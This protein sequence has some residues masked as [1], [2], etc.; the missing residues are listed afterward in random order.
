MITISLAQKK[1]FDVAADAYVFLLEQDFPFSSLEL[2]KRLYAPLESLLKERKFTGKAESSLL[3]TGVHE[4]KGVYLLLIGLGARDKHKKLS[5]EFYRRGI[6]RMVRFAESNQ[7]KKVV[8]SLAD[9]GHFGITVERLAQETSTIVFKSS[10][11]FDDFITSPER[12]L[13]R[14]TD[15]ICTLDR[16]HMKAAEAGL[17][18]GCI[19]AQSLNS[20][21]YWCDLPPCVLTPEKLAEHAESIGKECHLKTTIFDTKDIKKMGMGGLMAVSQGSAQ[22][23]RLA[24]LEYH[25]S[26]KAPTIALVGKGI[27]FDSGG[28][29]IKPAQGMETMKDDMSGAAA[30]LASMKAIAQLKPSVNVIG[31]APMAENMPSGTATRPGDIITFYNGKTA[32]VKNT[33]AEGRLILADA[34]AYAVKHYQL[35]AI[36]DLATLTGACSYALGPFYTGLFTQDD[37]LAGRLEAAAKTSGDRVWRLPMDE[38]YRKAVR[39]EV[40]D[41]C[42]SGNPAYRAGAIT[43]AFFL[44]NFVNS[45]PW[46]HLDIAGTA[47]G[48]PDLTYVRPGATGVGIRLLIDMIENW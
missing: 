39:S 22:G 42:N 46:A 3:V 16:K 27:T 37:D 47:F 17:Q 24:V 30:V 4:G 2:A 31:L 5:L 38:D 14:T 6:G 41:L 33:D 20:A 28:L 34:L 21:R 35:D 7:V 12:K 45:V 43:A 25:V 44:S 11:Y 40:A 13:F 19:I 9:A 18:R 8:L 10:Y 15:F 32:E 29:S 1:L 23:C 26:K 48:V 36:I